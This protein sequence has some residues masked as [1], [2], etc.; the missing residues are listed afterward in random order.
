MYFAGNLV[1]LIVLPS[2]Q[3]AIITTELKI[4]WLK[5]FLNH[6]KKVTVTYYE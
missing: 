2:N 3:L 5:K 6:E 4:Q 1:Y